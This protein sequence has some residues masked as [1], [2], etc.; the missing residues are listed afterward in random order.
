ML[1]LSVDVDEL[2][3]FA[4]SLE[5]ALKGLSRQGGGGMAGSTSSSSREAPVA[6]AEADA[7][8]SVSAI[9]NATSLHWLLGQ[10]AYDTGVRQ[11]AVPGKRV[12]W[13]GLGRL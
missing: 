8:G 5:A 10:V 9:L 13:G 4:S 7:G 1:E 11:F 6:A 12:G 2:L 3:K